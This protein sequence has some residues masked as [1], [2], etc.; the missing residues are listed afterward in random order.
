MHAYV[1]PNNTPLCD[2][3]NKDIFKVIIGGMVFHPDCMDSVSQSC[4]L[5]T[6]V[7][8]LNYLKDVADAVNIS[9]YPITTINTKYFLLISKYL[10]YVIPF[11]QVSQVVFNTKDI[12]GISSL[13]S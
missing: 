12:L 11:H 4:I 3:I 13:D 9:P 7:S 8:T 1:G 5:S 2:L 6:F 10:A